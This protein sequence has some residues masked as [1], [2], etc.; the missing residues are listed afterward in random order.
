MLIY[1]YNYTSKNAVHTL[2][3]AG[4]RLLS[5]KPIKLLNLNLN[6]TVMPDILIEPNME[7]SEEGRQ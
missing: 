5:I 4:Q 7:R 3:L 1:A 2:L 6:C